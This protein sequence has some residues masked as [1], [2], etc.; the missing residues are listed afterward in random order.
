MTHEAM[1]KRF[2]YL[3]NTTS[4]AI[5]KGYPKKDIKCGVCDRVLSEDDFPVMEYVKTK[6]GSENFYHHDCVLNA[7]K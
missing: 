1:V 2:K 5:K 4:T 6:S 3:T 7:W